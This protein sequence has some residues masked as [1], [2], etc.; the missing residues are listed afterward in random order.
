MIGT[1]FSILIAILLYF[2]E[3]PAESI[4]NTNFLALTMF[5]ISTLFIIT[6]TAVTIYAWIPLEKLEE[7][8]TPRVV[9]A[10]RKDRN[11]KIT[12]IFLFLFLFFSYAIVVDLL[13]LGIFNKQSLFVIW[14]LFLGVAVD[15][16]HHHLKRVMEFLD[17]YQV[18]GF[19]NKS[20]QG[21]VR[22]EKEAELCSWI[23]TFSEISMKA[24]KKNST[25]LATLA[26]ENLQMIAKNYL[27]AAK[28][29]TYHN[30]ED[31]KKFGGNDHVSYILF[32]LFQRFE[33]IFHKAL[34]E[35]LEPLC[36]KVVTTL[37]KLSLYGAKYDISLMGYPIYYLGKLTARA[38]GQGMQEVGN[39][40][41]LTLIEISKV[42]VQEVNL[43]YMEIKEPFITLINAM[44][45]IAK[46]SFRNDK[47]INIRV[48]TKPFYDLKTLFQSEK[49]QNHPDSP[50]IIHNLDAV[51]GEFTMLENV[52]STIPPVAEIIKEREQ[53]S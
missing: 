10:F 28:G 38:Q 43:Q 51:I 20:A 50:S 2:N 1:F 15:I 7:N 52:M 6:Q 14:T 12:N 32:Y 42:I 29:I 26:V 53:K 48:L 30:E 46:D 4:H 39:R 35:E 44:Q 40:A 31:S 8:L 18:M 36:S 41:G 33:L 13:F 3:L 11:L 23:D 5:L 45:T 37:G 16:L 34:K 47:S 24:I 25:S 22:G 17:P 21:C 19:F 49:L 27:E 9:E